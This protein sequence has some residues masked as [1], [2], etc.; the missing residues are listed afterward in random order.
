[1][2]VAEAVNDKLNESLSRQASDMP[3]NADDAANS[4]DAVLIERDGRFEMVS[5]KD[6]TAEQRST[7]DTEEDENGEKNENSDG[8]N[9]AHRGRELA[10]SSERQPRSKSA[11]SWVPTGMSRPTHR[12][13]EEDKLRLERQRLRR[14]ERKRLEEEK[15]LEEQEKKREACNAAF[16][17]WLR[18]KRSEAA[19]R[20]KEEK[21][22]KREQKKLE[23]E[24][25]SA[26][27]SSVN[28][29][30]SRNFE[31]HSDS[32]PWFMVQLANFVGAQR[33]IPVRNLICTCD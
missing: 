3:E 25:V 30:R 26:G 13:T 20:R 14:E 1:M 17:A 32:R 33:I 12:L 22:V 23:D 31:L 6:V 21:H 4:A 9:G 8:E 27:L 5:T 28:I 7:L 18:K 15:H 29:S 24:K 2:N 19:Q 10:R 11:Y 16:D